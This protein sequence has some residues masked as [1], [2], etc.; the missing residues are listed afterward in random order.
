MILEK[1]SNYWRAGR[2]GP[3]LDNI[4]FRVQRDRSVS[5]QAVQSGDGDITT[6]LPVDVVLNARGDARVLYFRFKVLQEFDWY[7]KHCQSTHQQCPC[8][9]GPFIR[10]S[11]RGCYQLSMERARKQSIGP[12][13]YGM[14]GYFDDLP[15]YKLD[16]DKARQLLAQAV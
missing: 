5:L 11:V 8:P 9:T 13:P 1:Y 16:L 10:I 15:Q 14:L 12:I 4:V 7:D 2:Q 6:D 3:H